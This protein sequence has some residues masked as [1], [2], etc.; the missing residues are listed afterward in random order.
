MELC[1]ELASDYRTYWLG[2]KNEGYCLSFIILSICSVSIAC[3]AV[4]NIVFF[5]EILEYCRVRSYD[6]EYVI[7]FLQNYVLFIYNYFSKWHTSVLK[8]TYIDCLL[9]NFWFPSPFPK[10]TIWFTRRDQ[11]LW[12]YIKKSRIS[13]IFSPK[14]LH[15]HIRF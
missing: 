9:Y 7:F 4:T 6:S 3:F 12:S 13:L 14:V 15:L 10:K 2:Q 8:N 11:A 1:S 5:Y